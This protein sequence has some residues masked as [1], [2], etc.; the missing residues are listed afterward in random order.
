M[1]Y[2][3]DYFDELI[4]DQT[5]FQKIA[6]E[7][8]RRRL[9][10]RGIELSD[11][12]I[13]SI[14]RSLGD[15]DKDSI[16]IQI[17]EDQLSTFA[18]SG[19]L[20]E[21]Y[22]SLD[23]SDAGEELEAILEERY[24]AF[25]KLI[26]DIVSELSGEMLKAVK[27]RNKKMLRGERKHQ[28]RFVK[29][30]HKLWKNP[31][32]LLAMMI[33]LCIEFGSNFN[34]AFRKGEI[35]ENPVVVEVITRLHARG[36]QVAQEILVLIQSGFADGAHA[37]WR[38]LHE[39]AVTA[40]FIAKHGEETANR[41]L[42][43]DAV[44]SYRSSKLYKKYAERLGYAPISESEFEGLERAYQDLV[45]EYG[46]SFGSQY[47]WASIDLSKKR[48]T[49]RDIEE[50]AGLDQLRPYYK[51]AS[52]NVHANPKGVLFRLGLYPETSDILLA[53][54][55]DVGF[56]DPGQG[57]AISLAQITTIL[58]TQS[59]NIDRLVKCRVLFDLEREISARFVDSQSSLEKNSAA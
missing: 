21:H 41:Y 11:D 26:P 8:I 1:S 45:S 34:D 9:A 2:F 42:L 44:E 54:P 59:P 39:I 19:E 6:T 28:Q 25:G 16:S 48:P 55:S 3:Q 22:Y 17:D 40:F 27:S 56:A 32:D 58:L 14:E 51:L 7:V 5:S 29:R 38:S 47:G 20:D 46:K 33:T 52:H 24:Q 10:Q 30:I 4:K 31:L 13:D 43:H 12:Q 37:R 36:C 23:L 18:S 35:E 50:D 53:G 15:L 49:F 57:T